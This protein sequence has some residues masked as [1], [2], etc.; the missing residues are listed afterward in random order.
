MHF[1]CSVVT[2]PLRA[3]PNHR[4]EMISQLLFG[5]S[6]KKIDENEYWIK[7]IAEYDN[8]IGWVEKKSLQSVEN[9]S[10][11]FQKKILSGEIK[12]KNATTKHYIKL[13]PG[14]EIFVNNNNEIYFSNQILKSLEPFDFIGIDEFAWH[15]IEDEILQT[16]SSFLKSAIEYPISKNVKSFCMFCIL[17]S[18]FAKKIA[19]KND[20]I[21]VIQSIL[22][23]MSFNSF[24]F[25][26]SSNP[27]PEP[28]I[29][30]FN[31][32]QSTM[33]NGDFVIFV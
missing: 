23:F 1:Q 2:A 15:F 16:A 21:G 9:I 12:F 6:V 27:F 10:S 5:E 14:S 8:Y 25:V 28:S 32:E 11:G 3:E 33:N 13:L 4:A 24:I 29:I 26:K 30:S 7:I 22:L 31:P 17:V 20:D 19:L 18:G